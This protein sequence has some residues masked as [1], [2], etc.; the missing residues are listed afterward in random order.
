MHFGNDLQINDAGYLSRNSTNY[1]HWQLNRRFTELPAQ[2]RYMSKDWRWRVSTD[3]NDHGQLLNHQ[4]RISRESRLRNGSYE[5]GEININSAGLDDLLT[6]GHGAVRLPPNIRSYFEY[7]RPRQGNWAH[8]MELEAISGGL[9]GNDQVGYSINYEPT[10]F[11]SHALNVYLG[12]YFSRTPDWL[13]WQRDNLIGSFDGKE[14][15]FS[16]G[17][18]WVMTN[19]QE[20]RLK[21]QAIA[22]AAD[23]RQAYRVDPTGS[24]V[25]TAESVDDFT[26]RNLGLQIRYRYEIAPLSYLY[27][28][29]GRGGYEQETDDRNS[30]RVLR[31]S[32]NLRDDDQ[33]LVKISYRFES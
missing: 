29:Y 10:Y 4:F 25:A 26:V 22:V 7:E 24:A 28:V 20:L 18:N 19:R 1:A 3:Y 6:R 5:Y 17:F 31:D 23:L 15:Q 12:L 11:I 2:S 33:L 8:Y 21:L 32:F 16:A 27:V 13:V 9:A 14:S 30:G